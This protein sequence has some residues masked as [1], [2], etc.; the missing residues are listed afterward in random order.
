MRVSVASVGRGDFNTR[1]LIL[2]DGFRINDG[3]YNAGAIDLEFPIDVDL[4]DRVE[5]A[6]GPS[7]SLYGTSAF[8]GVVNIITKT[9]RQLGGA[10]LAGSLGSFSTGDG[11]VTYGDRFTNGVDL[12]MSG[13]LTDSGGQD[14]FFSEFLDVNGGIAEGADYERARSVFGKLSFHGFTVLGDSVSR[15]KGIPTASYAT[16]FNDADTFTVDG[17]TRVGVT[18]DHRFNTGLVLSSRVGYDDIHEDGEYVYDWAEE[19]GDP[20]DLVTNID[21]YQTQRISS[22]FTLTKQVSARHRVV[23]GSEYRNNFV[24]HQK[25]FDREVYQDDMRN[26]GV[27]GVYA[28]DEFWLT[29][30]FI[31]NAGLRYDRYGFDTRTS[32]V[33]PRVAVIYSPAEATTLKVLYGTA[34]RAPSTYELYFDDGGYFNKAALTLDPERM[35]SAEVVVEQRIGTGWQLTGSV[36][37]YAIDNLI[38]QKLT[39]RTGCMCTTTSSGFTRPASSWSWKGE[40]PAVGQDARGT[41]DS[42]PVRTRGACVCRTPRRTWSSSISLRRCSTKRSLRV[43]KGFISAAAKP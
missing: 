33:S 14:L 7:S 9:G 15:R 16:V 23:V 3:V 20:Q 13:T 2:V 27:W 38:T 36:Y 28:Q 24:L 30:N 5:I 17:S 6:R 39:G 34:F 37:R 8:F 4:I 21:R 1:L 41:A 31:L 22:E 29:D 12:I 43:P 25:N 32:N 26:S 11:R 42:A 10:Q 18:Y 40:P 19:E 35:R